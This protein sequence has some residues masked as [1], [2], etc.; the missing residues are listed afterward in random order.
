MI[1]PIRRIVAGIA[2]L[3]GEDPIMTAAVDIAEST[4][5][6]LHL[7]HAFELPSLAWDAYAR[8]GYVDASEL[9]S[10]ADALCARLERAVAVHAPAGRLLYHAIAAPPATAIHAVAEEQQADLIIVG[11]S[12]HRAVARVLLGIT[13]Q[14]V[15]RQANAP[16]LILREPLQ[17][18]IRNVLLTTDL[19]HFSAGVHEL[20][21]DV[22]ETLA[23]DAK[24]AVRSLLV[25][26]PV[27]H[28]PPPLPEEQIEEFARDQLE[29]FLGDRRDRG[30]TIEG[31]IRIGEPSAEIVKEAEASR[32]DL[33]VLGTHSRKGVDRWLAGSVTETTIRETGANVLVIPA[34]LEEQRQLPVSRDSLAAPMPITG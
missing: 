23:G 11:P 25:V 34:G 6:E 16:V 4:G 29:R 9:D 27:L 26:G 18:P 22:M 17:K 12:R 20:G 5:A 32:P 31:F 30:R 13:A 19:G 2:S 8:M 7:V 21:L 24:P 28:L 1:Y 14:R 15:V 10:Y 3:D 33:I